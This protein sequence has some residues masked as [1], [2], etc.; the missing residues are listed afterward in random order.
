MIRHAEKGEHGERFSRAY[1]LCTV[2]AVAGKKV[3]LIS[4]PYFTLHRMSRNKKNGPGTTAEK[5]N[6]AIISYTG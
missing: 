3:W 6:Y 1:L 4:R 2:H 5:I